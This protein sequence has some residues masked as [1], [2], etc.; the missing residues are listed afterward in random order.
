MVGSISK[1]NL[2]A[3]IFGRYRPDSAAVWR[4]F[5]RRVLR[6]KALSMRAESHLESMCLEMKPI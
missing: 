3:T 1:K 4:K 5:V 2:S 6:R